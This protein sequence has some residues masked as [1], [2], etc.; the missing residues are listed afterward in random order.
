MSTIIIIEKSDIK[1]EKNEG[2]NR[3]RL[4]NIIRKIVFIFTGLFLSDV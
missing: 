3:P 4:T 1:T 2:K